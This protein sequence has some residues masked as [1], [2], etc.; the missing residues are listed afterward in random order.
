MLLL[1][2]VAP[3]GTYFGSVLLG[4]AALRARDGLHARPG[5]DRRDA[6]RP[7][8]RRAASASGLLNTSRLVGGALG[9]A[10]LCTI[11][12]AQTRAGRRRGRA[13]ADER[14]RPRVHRRRR[15]SRSPAPRSPGCGCATRSPPALA[16]AARRRDRGADRG[17]RGARRVGGAAAQRPVEPRPPAP[18]VVPSRSPATATSA[19]AS[20]RAIRSWAMRSPRSI[21][22]GSAGSLLCRITIT[23]PR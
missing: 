2:G 6:G 16:A 17:G 22:N 21:A 23:S 3:G 12:A 10:V 11:A 7:P 5:D 14:L 9:L 15:C 4:R 20:P 8:D 13:R 18:R 19:A 1:S